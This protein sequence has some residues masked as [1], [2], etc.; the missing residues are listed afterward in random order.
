M[1]TKKPITDVV[2]EREDVQS[3]KNVVKQEKKVGRPRVDGAV[4]NKKIVLYLTP[5]QH[6]DI[7]DY[8]HAHRLKVSSY[9][10]DTFFEQ[11]YRELEKSDIERFIES[12]DEEKLGRVVKDWLANKEN[13]NQ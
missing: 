8:C 1:S 7:S 6:D 4:K 5:E 12:I 13:K 3:L 2:K 10:K 11:F 9:I